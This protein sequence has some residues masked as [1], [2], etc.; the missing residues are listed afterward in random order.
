MIHRTANGLKAAPHTGRH[1]ART[2]V[3]ESS[4]GDSLVVLR[5]LVAGDAVIFVEPGAEVEEFAALA[6]EGEVGQV[7][8][9]RVFQFLAAVE[10]VNRRNLW[11]IANCKL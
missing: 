3:R 1:A 5:R 7:G 11:L 9:F 2:S 8:D 10:A 6:A 4:A